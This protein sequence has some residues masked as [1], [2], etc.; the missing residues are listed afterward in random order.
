MGQCFLQAF[1]I[2]QWA[3]KGGESSCHYLLDGL[4]GAAPDLLLLGSALG[5]NYPI[6][7][8]AVLPNFPVFC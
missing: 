6:E 8:C 2:F 4:W 5:G 7:V 3:V 1:P